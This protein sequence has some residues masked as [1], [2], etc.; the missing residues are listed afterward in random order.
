MH[1]L[2]HCRHIENLKPLCSFCLNGIVPRNKIDVLVKELLKYRLLD[3]VALVL[4][5]AD[6]ISTKG[7][8]TIPFVDKLVRLLYSPA[9][10]LLH[11]IN[12]TVCIRAIPLWGIGRKLSK[13]RLRAWHPRARYL[14]HITSRRRLLINGWLPASRQFVVRRGTF[15]RRRL[16]RT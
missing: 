14:C 6:E 11:A 3:I 8:G 1:Q 10:I 16:S 12:S 5:K 4:G 13:L 2:I 15:I 9:S 7:K